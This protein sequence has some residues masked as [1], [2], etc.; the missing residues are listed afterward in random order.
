MQDTTTFPKIFSPHTKAFLHSMDN[1]SNYRTDDVI[2]YF[3]GSLLCYRKKVEIL[4][5]DGKSASVVFPVHELPQL[6]ECAVVLDNALYI[7]TSHQV[8][9]IRHVRECEEEVYIANDTE[10]LSNIVGSYLREIRVT[11]EKKSLENVS[12]TWTFVNIQTDKDS[13]NLRWVGESNGYYS[14]TVQVEDI[15]CLTPALEWVNKNIL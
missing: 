6:I 10:S 7:F 11:T 1:W 9:L 4:I 12:T 5:E 3:S 8:I 13:C 15:T 14:E 2:K